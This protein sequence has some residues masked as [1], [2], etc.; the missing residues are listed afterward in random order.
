MRPA[1]LR[2]ARRRP[3]RVWR[4]AGWSAFGLQQLL[5]SIAFAELAKQYR[6]AY[7]PFLLEGMGD[8]VELFQPDRIHPTEA[9]QPIIVDNV[10]RALAP[11]IKRK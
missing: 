7:L 3:R 11:L 1:K 6:T 9:A 4:T 5:D 10:W 8:K 2:A